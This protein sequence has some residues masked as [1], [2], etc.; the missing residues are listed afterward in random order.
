MFVFFLL[1]LLFYVDLREQNQFSCL[2]LDEARPHYA[3]YFNDFLLFANT[4]SE[5]F[6]E[7]WEYD[8]FMENMDGNDQCIVCYRIYQLY[9]TQSIRKCF[10]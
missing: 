7:N 9:Y 3:N 5:M 4:R 2:A 8:I 10:Q 6:D 1:C